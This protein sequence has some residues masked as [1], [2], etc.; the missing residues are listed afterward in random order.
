VANETDGLDPRALVDAIRAAPF[1]VFVLDDSGAIVFGSDRARELADVEA[2]IGGGLETIAELVRDTGSK[3]TGANQFALAAAL[4]ATDRGSIPMSIQARR[5][6]PK[7]GGMT[8][9]WVVEGTAADAERIVE[10]V[11]VLAR[12]HLDE[13]STSLET[14]ER[15]RARLASVIDAV[16]TGLEAGVLLVDDRLVVV[17]ATDQAIQLLRIGRRELI[18]RELASI[19]GGES[20]AEAVALSDHPA[21]AV[22]VIERTGGDL[23]VACARVADEH[24]TVIVLQEAAP[25]G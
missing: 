1:A 24:G 21:R 15:D 3:V 4:A 25:G 19:P 12:R 23:R 6:G 11:M 10:D 14:S 13:L 8:V 17:D 5:L 18:G 16:T 20:L 2:E 9:V 7:P 22:R